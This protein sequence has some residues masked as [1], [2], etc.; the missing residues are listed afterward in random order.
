MSNVSSR[1]TLAR[2]ILVVDPPGLHLAAVAFAYPILERRLTYS[3]AISSLMR[4]ALRERAIADGSDS[5]LHGLRL[6]IERTLNQTIADI[7]QD[8][9]DDIRKEL[10]ILIIRRAP[11][12]VLFEMA[13]SAND[14]HAKALPKSCVDYI[15]VSEVRK[16]LQLPTLGRDPS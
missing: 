16:A 13:Y 9:A 2:T 6:R 12:V 7:S 15:V 3:D 14:R 5:Y 4:A 8:A 11:K 1:Q 10:E